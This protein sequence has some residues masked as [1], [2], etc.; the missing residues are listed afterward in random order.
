[1]I[2]G[3]AIMKGTKDHGILTKLV[4]HRGRRERGGNA[5]KT[6]SHG[7]R[8]NGRPMLRPER[9]RTQASDISG[10]GL[11]PAT[12]GPKRA[13]LRRRVTRSLFP[14]QRSSHSC[15]R[16]FVAPVHRSFIATIAAANSASVFSSV[17]E[18]PRDENQGAQ[19]ERS[20]IV[21]SMVEP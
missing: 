14:I 5:E 6:A 18:H 12:F 11:R 13:A 1:M 8:P 19:L 17:D 15:F 16:V 3:A 10:S 2:R 21:S 9:D 7:G 20:A 4:N